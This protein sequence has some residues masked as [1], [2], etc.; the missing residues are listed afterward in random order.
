MRK[1]KLL[2]KGK[3]KKKNAIDKLI[4]KEMAPTIKCLGKNHSSDDSRQFPCQYTIYKTLH[5]S[6]K[7]D[8]TIP[9]F[10]FF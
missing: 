3:F 7:H 1:K 2:M 8:I 9:I 10:S 6:L 5:W 4:L